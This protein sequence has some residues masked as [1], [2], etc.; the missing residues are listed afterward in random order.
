MFATE[1][2]T[3]LISRETQ[4]SRKAREQGRQATGIPEPCRT[5]GKRPLE[6]KTNSGLDWGLAEKQANPQLAGTDIRFRA[7]RLIP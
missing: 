2:K 6:L 7:N 1:P 5:Q 4:L 3:Q